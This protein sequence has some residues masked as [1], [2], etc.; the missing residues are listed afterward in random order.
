M[1]RADRLFRIVQTLRNRRLL[2]AKTLAGMLHVSTRTIYR[3]MSDLQRAGVPITGSAGVGYRLDARAVLP[4]LAFTGEEI[5][6]LVLGTRMAI[7]WAD[8]SLAAAARSVVD[9]VEAV[10][11]DPLKAVLV[12]TP[13]YVPGGEWTRQ[14]TIGLEQLRQ[15]ITERQKVEFGYARADGA[16]T[17]RVVWPLGLYFWGSSWNLAAWCELRQAYRSFRPDRMAGLVARDER[18]PKGGQINLAGFLA[19]READDARHG[20]E[21]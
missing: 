7:S 12:D 21:L 5:E 17:R 10:L 11:P 20:V 9:K 15:A 3:D 2:T 14:R 19:E 16:V 4:P 13:L 8:P 6:A 1:R 18:F